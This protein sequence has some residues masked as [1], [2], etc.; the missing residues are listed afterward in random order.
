MYAPGILYGLPKIRKPDSK[1]LFQ[2]RP[3]F[4]SY[5]SSSFKI[6]KYLTKILPPLTFNECPVE[7]SQ[8]FSISVANIPNA[9]SCY[10]VSIDVDNLFTNVP[11]SETISNFLNHLFIQSDTFKNVTRDVF[12]KML[13]L[14]VKN[15]F[16]FVDGKLY[17]QVKGLGMGLPLGP[18]FDNIFMYF[19]E[20]IWLPHRPASFKPVFIRGVLMMF[21]C[22][23]RINPIQH[24]FRLY[25]WEAS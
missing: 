23:S 4:A 12:K 2:L 9:D 10:K 3:I 24:F 21:S 8:Q 7:N 20:L 17:N 15:S 16:F 18:T 19:N 1:N 25:K 6:S 5:K 22:Y 13:E 11:P 14:S